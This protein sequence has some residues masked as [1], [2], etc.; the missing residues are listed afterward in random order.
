MMFTKSERN[1]Y[2]KLL[3]EDKLPP[4]ISFVGNNIISRKTIPKKIKMGCV[5]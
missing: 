1:T 2:L 4:E 5:V 3:I